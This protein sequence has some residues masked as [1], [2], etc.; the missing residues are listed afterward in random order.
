MSAS[1][2]DV[3]STWLQNL[4]DPEAVHRLVAP[5]ATYVSLNAE[6]AELKKILPWTGTSQGPQA[7]LDNLGGMFTRWENQA[8]NV[9]T[10]FGSGENVAVFGDFRY[11]SHS[12]DK[13][14]TSPFAMLV[15]VVDGKVTYLQFLEDT[16]ATAASFRKEGTWTV[17]TL[18]EEQPFMV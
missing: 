17:Q 8:F 18:L 6:D 11:K 7:F 5:D 14:V 13:V 3:V 9:T 12:L 16:Y 4:L 1:P 2:M 15:K 10:M